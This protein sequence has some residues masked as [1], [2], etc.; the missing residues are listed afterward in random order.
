M[1]VEQSRLVASCS[2]KLGDLLGGKIKIKIAGAHGGEYGRR[3]SGSQVLR[4]SGFR[5]AAWKNVGATGTGPLL[6][7]GRRGRSM[8]CELLV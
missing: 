6:F 7:L 4:F 5:L 1:E 3:C 8:A 2:W